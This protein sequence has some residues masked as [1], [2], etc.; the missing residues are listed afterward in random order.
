[1][2]NTHYHTIVVGGGIAGLTAAVYLAKAGKKTILFE[3]NNEFGGLV[4]TF[5]RDGFLFEGG[6][7]ALENAGIIFPMLKDLGITL[8]TVRSK[9][10]IGIENEVLNIEDLSSIDEY[11]TMLVKLYPESAAEIDI[12]IRK[13]RKVM[14]HLDVLYGIE[15]PA[16][17][18][19]K[20]DKKYL[21]RQLLPWL[22]KFLFT[23]GKINRFNE[24]IEDYLKKII[25][26]PSLRDI[27]SQ[28]FF[29]GTPG[30][31]AMSY[32][33]L[34]LDYVYP[35]GGV[36][37]LAK[38]VTQ[39]IIDHNGELR[40]DTIIK[41]VDA[42]KQ[43]VTDD[44][45]NTYSYDNLIW[46]ADLKTFYSITNTDNLSEN[47]IKKHNKIKEKILSSVGSESVYSLYLEVDLPLDYFRKIAHGHF[48]YTPSKQGLNNIHST[49]LKTLLE[50]WKKNKKADVIKWLDQ[51]IK[52][53]TYEISIPGLKDP[54]MVPENKT[55]V[56][57]SFLADYNLFN[58]I[59]NDG[60]EEEFKQEI[61]SRII[62]VL[63]N[64]IYPKLGSHIYK[65]FAFTPISIKNRVGSSEGAIVGWS[66]E[67]PL[68]VIHKIHKSNKSVLTAIPNIFQAGQWAYSPAGVPMSILTG[69]LAADKII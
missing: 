7:R 8:N 49:G 5:K 40:Q 15:N 18:N 2:S 54:S 32:F 37:T 26:N 44:N 48:F 46:A 36:G 51:F 23:V 30:F 67:D 63:S 55:G 64:S 53:N 45:G 60:W 61:E 31:F 65:Q 12:F 4:S 39:K 38:A 68:P 11:K 27:I 19:I 35:L 14:K 25:S 58:N 29:K 28:H 34:Y 1:M 56:I 50:N 13:M 20:Q 17:K 43:T 6:L 21:F 22:P 42:Y 9:V 59:R 10:S 47:I 66:F 57:I 41:T 24:P 3:K 69:K 52:L 62:D 16:F 33:S